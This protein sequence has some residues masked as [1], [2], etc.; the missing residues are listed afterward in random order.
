MC[1]PLG[2]SVLGRLRSSGVRDLLLSQGV[3]GPEELRANALEAGVCP[4][5]LGLCLST[6]C[7]VICGDYN[8]AFD[9]HVFLK[10]FFLEPSTSSMC[11]LLIDE[12]ANLPSRSIDYYSPK[13]SL[14]WISALLASDGIPKKIRKL[15]NAWPGAFAEWDRCLVSEGV[16]EIE[17]P[18]DTNI[19]LAPEVWQRAMEKVRDPSRILMDL[20][21]SLMDFSRLHPETDPRYHLVFTRDNEDRILQWYCTDPSRHLAERMNSCHSV[22][23]FSATLSPSDHYAGS[24]GFLASDERPIIQDVPYPF[25]AEN[26]G[27]WID[28]RIDTRYR[29]RSDSSPLLA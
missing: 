1:V 11:A 7:D 27:V 21:R 26:L 14:S 5:E 19:P 16:N 4:F 8:Y 18:S 20:Y 12:A 29:C 2:I 17:L 3:I 9:P 13:I 28:P 6:D 23:A 15:L 10:R 22:V 24:L 25:P